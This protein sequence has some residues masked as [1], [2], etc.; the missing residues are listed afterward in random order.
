MLTAVS[1][2]VIVETFARYVQTEN[3]PSYFPIIHERCQ[4]HVFFADTGFNTLRREIGR[5]HV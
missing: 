1:S 2:P 4:V 5:A 3:T